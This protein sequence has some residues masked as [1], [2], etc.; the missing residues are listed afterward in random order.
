MSIKYKVSGGCV[1]CLMCVY[2]CNFGAI[3]IREDVSTVIDQDKC[4]GCGSCFRNC[5][6][7]AIVKVEEQK[8][9]NI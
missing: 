5:Q 6:T 2:E 9:E 4:V 7:G 3:S 8:G 1:L